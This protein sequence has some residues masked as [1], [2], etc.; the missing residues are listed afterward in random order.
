MDMVN[1]TELEESFS[2]N[3]YELDSKLKC[4]A[5]DD[6]ESFI[7]LDLGLTPPSEE[8]EFRI[9]F[10]NL[11][12]SEFKTPFPADSLLDKGR[13]FPL[14]NSTDLS[15]LGDMSTI[16]C[17]ELAG[18]LNPKLPSRRE[19][20]NGKFPAAKRKVRITLPVCDDSS[21]LGEGNDRHE[22]NGKFIGRLKNREVIGGRK[23]SKLVTTINGGAMRL[24]IKFRSGKIF[25]TFISLV[26]SYHSFP[27]HSTRRNKSRDPESI[28]TYQRLTKPLQRWLTQSFN[29]INRSISSNNYNNN[30]KQEEKEESSI[31]EV[32]SRVIEIEDH[33][34]RD[35]DDVNLC[36]DCKDVKIKSSSSS[37]KRSE[38]HSGVLRGNMSFVERENSIRAAIA[39]CK[40]SV[41]DAVYYFR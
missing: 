41:G 34:S 9:S 11:P 36:I 23:P 30:N 19:I 12:L 37:T 35:L 22:K 10:S 16:S 1:S 27:Y 18:S 4:F 38:Y 24:L 31:I 2:F 14:Q 40:R 13:I 15:F 21:N 26:K 39:H 25:S 28:W 29:I 20:P 6:E 33:N 17:Q 8:F 7:E 3:C 5:S 32:K